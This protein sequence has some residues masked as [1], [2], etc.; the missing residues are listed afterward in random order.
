MIFLLC[1]I[2]N[3]ELR[4]PIYGNQSA[5]ASLPERLS[6]TNKSKI[7]NRK[8]KIDASKGGVS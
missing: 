1:L 8:S 2:F 4:L 7:K 5:L 6:Q 3:F